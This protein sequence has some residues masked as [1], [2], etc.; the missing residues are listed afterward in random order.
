MQIIFFK[1]LWFQAN[2]GSWRT[3][4]FWNG[5]VLGNGQEGMKSSL[6]GDTYPNLIEKIHQD[7]Y[8]NML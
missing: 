7:R 4:K 2:V 5:G 1:N 3:E 6:E 8:N